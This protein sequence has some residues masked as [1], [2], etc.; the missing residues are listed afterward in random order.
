MKVNHLAIAVKDIKLSRELWAKLL[1]MEP[2]DIHTLEDRGVYACTLDTQNLTI[3]LV[4]PID[5]K[6]PIW[7]FVSEKGGG[8]HH[9]A[10]ETAD[11][12]SD[13]ERGKSHGFQFLGD[14]PVE[15]LDNT[16]VIFLH[17]KSLGV[18]VELVEP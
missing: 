12:V 7:K 1:K 15:G 3:E 6:S 2:P 13:I 5:E 9:I 8:L 14:H 16:K 17:P 18:L 11:I 4:Q 10:L